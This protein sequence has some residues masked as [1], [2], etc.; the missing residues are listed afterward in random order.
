VRAVVQRVRHARVEVNGRQTGAIGEGLAVLLGVMKTDTAREAIQL[1]DKV[2]RLR[3]FQQDGRM[4]LSALDIGGGILVIP[5]FTVC[6]RPD[7]NRLSFDPAAPP[8][9][10][11]QLYELFVERCR[12]HPVQVATGAFQEI[13]SVILE[14]TG[15]V[16][17]ILTAG[18]DPGL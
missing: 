11:R 8:E 12:T 15:P 18:M 13:M 2:V 16:T 6:G 10:A 9:I 5:Q 17:A 7:G 4:K 3:V 14:N 1:A